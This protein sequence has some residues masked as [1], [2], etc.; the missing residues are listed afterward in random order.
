MT[1]IK[2]ATLGSSVSIWHC[3]LEGSSL[4]GSHCWELSKP[5]E[6]SS[7]QKC[8]ELEG[9]GPREVEEWNGVP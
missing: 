5:L 7:F 1:F 2:P 3:S 4:G 9:L 6:A 8:K